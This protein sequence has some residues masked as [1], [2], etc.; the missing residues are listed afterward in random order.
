MS[1]VVRGV[2][3]ETYLALKAE[4]DRLQADYTKAMEVVANLIAERDDLLL[5]YTMKHGDWRAEGLCILE[6]VVARIEARRRP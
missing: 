5:Y 3:Y 4:R 6:D 1:G 2:S